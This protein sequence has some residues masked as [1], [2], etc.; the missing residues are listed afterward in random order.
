MIRVRTESKGLQFLV[1][2]EGDVPR[3]VVGDEAK[4]RQ[5]LVNLLGNAVKFTDAGG[6]AFRV[7]MTATGVVF[8]LEDTGFRIAP[9]ELGSLFEA[10]GQTESGRRAKE[11][12]GLGLAIS[13]NFVRLMGGDIVVRSELDRGSTFVVELP[14]P[15]AD[16]VVVG[17][18]PRRVVGLS[19]GQT[20]WR[21]LVV[22]DTPE[23]R[24][25]LTSLLATVGFEVR[26]ATN[27]LEAVELWRSWRPHLIW[28]DMRMP[29][30]DGYAAVQRIR[31]LAAGEPCRI[32]ALTASAFHHDRERILSERCDDFVPKPF[33]ET[34]IFEKLTEHLGV[35]FE[36]DDEE[37][38]EA[39]ASSAESDE[40][41]LPERL[42]AL[43]PDLLAS[44]RNPMMRGDVEAAL[45]AVGQ[46]R[47]RDEALAGALHRLL[48]SYRF[49]DLLDALE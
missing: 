6:I 34:T 20:T 23:N 24:A 39:A 48:R 33:R 31:E 35:Q 13:R 38:S 3:S 25:L 21:L 2:I 49:E 10:F 42:M 19:P 32:I 43:P 9:E 18:K 41:V 27:G 16:G 26:E 17:A 22:D 36:Y 15:I 45:A 40:V 37:R 7:G 8:E 4:L 47:E 30:M 1:T 44:L 29:V 28:M 5:V 14:L 12:T 46:I 11:G